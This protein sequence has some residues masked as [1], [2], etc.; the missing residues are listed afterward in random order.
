MG[1]SELVSNLQARKA[2]GK[3]TDATVENIW[4]DFLEPVFR[5]LGWE[6]AEPKGLNTIDPFL[7]LG[8]VARIAIAGG[9][10][11][12]SRGR[13]RAEVFLEISPGTRI[14]VITNFDEWEVLFKRE[15]IAEFRAEEFV[16]PDVRIESEA[17]HKLVRLIGRDAIEDRGYLGVANQLYQQRVDEQEIDLYV[18]ELN[19]LRKMIGDFLIQNPKEISSI[20][21]SKAVRTAYEIMGI[22]GKKPDRDRDETT[23]NQVIQRL[24]DRFIIFRFAEDN[25]IL[26][27]GNPKP[28]SD[29]YYRQLLDKPSEVLAKQDT[30]WR[31]IAGRRDAG[32]AG[33]FG[34]FANTYNGGVFEPIEGAH[35]DRVS[36][37]PLNDELVRRMVDLI[38]KR[39]VKKKL[40]RLLGY[41]YEKYIGERLY[42]FGNASDEKRVAEAA[43]LTTTLARSLTQRLKDEGRAF[44]QLGNTPEKKKQAIYYTPEDVTQ[45]ISRQ[46]VG[47]LLD[48]LY[49]D[50]EKAKTVSGSEGAAGLLA[51]FEK[52]RCLTVV[53]PTCGSGA[54]LIEA[55]ALVRQFYRALAKAMAEHLGAKH[56]E[57]S[58]AEIRRRANSADLLDFGEA[59]VSLK[60]PGVFALNWNIYGVDIDPRAVEICSV[61]LMIQ[62]IEELVR[63]QTGE[64][65]RF[66]S[67]MGENI[68]R[69]NSLLCDLPTHE[70][71][72]LF[73]GKERELTEL[74]S[75]RNKVKKAPDD[76]TRSSLRS[77]IERQTARLSRL[78]PA[79]IDRTLYP[80]NWPVEFPEVFFGPQAGFSAVIG[81]PPYARVQPDWPREPLNDTFRSALGQWSRDENTYT[82]FVEHMV[83]LLSCTGR[84]G[85]IVP[86][87]LT[88]STKQPFKRLRTFM[89]NAE[90]D[91]YVASFDRIPS[92]IFGNDVR[93]RCS[94]VVFDAGGSAPHRVF[95]TSLLR[96]NA[97]ERDQLFS[98]IRYFEIEREI[99]DG[100]LKVGST[101]QSDTLR[102]LHATGHRLAETL[103]QTMPFSELAQRAPKFPP[104]S[105]FVGGVAYNWFPAWRDVPETTTSEGRPSLPQRT[106]GYRF[107]SEQDADF[108][109]AILCSSFTYWYWA[110]ASDG[111]N[112]KKWLIASIPLSKA[113]FTATSRRRMA[114]LGGK[115]RRELRKQY[116]YKENRGRIGNY[117]LLA[118]RSLTHEIDEAMSAGCTVLSR[119]FF[120]DIYGFIDS[121]IRTLPRELVDDIGEEDDE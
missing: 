9:R 48:E 22:T 104:A 4:S 20:K 82:F 95:S 116:V 97:S 63:P 85:L 99:A 21:R 19:E 55:L 11:R 62:V 72:T 14:S 84:S 98:R 52:A 10:V 79:V 61:S 36:E 17:W 38:V 73:V 3:F 13:S 80:L 29:L 45:Y 112:L 78:T 42:I 2:E 58:D 121:F 32:M 56:L 101:L 46:T 49:E 103:G 60:A 102:R 35:P 41:I 31:M 44:V 87:S 111:F 1:I 67:I 28:L 93:T 51:L 110:I 40:A 43:G 53:D 113:S 8:G 119:R 26:V 47:V 54:F 24:I 88:F 7:E 86:L 6:Q 115:L 57:E 25:N 91:W 90:G 96:W 68:K 70:W 92:A 12:S 117:N 50:L 75:L 76:E 23:L 27:D 69:G 39:P 77:Q 5:L 109:F 114:L 83:N 107:Q 89:E 15:T 33:L 105:V 65:V 118:C 71:R 94:I 30:V 81:N 74:V 120:S 108:V 100:I 34:E 64:L 106:A 66:P 18:R 59:L 16:S 37:L